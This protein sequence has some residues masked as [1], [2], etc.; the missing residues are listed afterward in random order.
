MKRQI[1]KTVGVTTKLQK[2]LS[3]VTPTVLF[4]SIPF[5]GNCTYLPTILS[6]CSPICRTLAE[7]S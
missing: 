5:K 4:D 1:N 7:G 2:Q 3:M 6:N